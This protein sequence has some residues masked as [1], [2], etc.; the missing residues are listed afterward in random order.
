MDIGFGWG[1]GMKKS[2]I[3]TP[4]KFLLVQKSYISDNSPLRGHLN[5]ATTYKVIIYNLFNI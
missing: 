5:S 1:R 4:L 3:Y 2:N